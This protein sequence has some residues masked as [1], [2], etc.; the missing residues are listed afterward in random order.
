MRNRKQL[1]EQGYDVHRMARARRARLRGLF[2]KG[3]LVIL[4]L[5]F[6]TA[7]VVDYL[8][9]LPRERIAK[10]ASYWDKVKLGAEKAVRAAYLSLNAYDEDP[11]HSQLPI[12]ELYIKGKRLDKLTA[13]LPASGAEY[14]SARV[15]LE[16]KEFKADVRF[17]GD[18]I[19]HWAFPNRSWRVRLA[20][21][22]DYNGMQYFNLNVPRVD[23]QISNWLGYDIA[24]TLSGGLVP[25]SDFVHFR[26]NRLYD[27]VR[28]FLEQP[29]QDFLRKRNL[30][31]GKIFVGDI[32]SEQIYGGQPRKHLYRD[33]SAW[34]IRGLVEGER[35]DEIA[36]LVRIIRE[37]HD[38]Y[39]FYYAID[40]VFD[41]DALTKFIATLELV[42]TVH[43]DET[44]NGKYYFNP[45]TGKFI[46]IV[47]DTVAY[48]WKNRAQLDLAS[49]SLFRVVLANPE[50]REK[51]DR[52]LWTAINGDL[53]TEKIQQKVINKADEIRLDIYSFPLKL[54][55]NDKGIRHVSN[56]EWNAAVQELLGVIRERN[57]YIRSELS[58]TAVSQRFLPETDATPGRVAFSVGSRAGYI[59]RALKVKLGSNDAG[60]NVTLR[61]RGI[62]D[63]G[64][65]IKG[66]YREQVATSK[67]GQVT[68]T[69]NDTLYSKRSFRKNKKVG[70][71]IP[72]TYV[73]EVVAEGPAQVTKVVRVRGRNSITKE[74]YAPVEDVELDVPAEHKKN[75]VWWAPD[76]FADAKI[77]TLQGN[78]HLKA[79]KEVDRFTTLRIQPGT[80]LKMDPGV[81]LVVRGGTLEMLGSA[82]QPIRVEA[83]SADNPWGVLALNNGA[84]A[85]LRHVAIHG[86]GDATVSHVRYDG[87]LSVY[88]SKATLER[89]VVYSL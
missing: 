54:H 1:E 83:R 47:W 32:T 51:K 20:K 61:R 75:S 52:A 49:N 3:A 73:Y 15:K 16:N 11:K 37:E 21:G 25:Y 9:H 60:I 4:G 6:V 82:A 71:V 69:L 13:S 57:D 28:L 45:V 88:H 26:L 43:I 56:E 24:R 39:E 10:R 41:L 14:Q 70:E 8:S 81:S 46:P 55:A 38:P 78:V 50:L 64:R 87:S 62:D 34:D 66:E 72:A 12:V 36:E 76:H 53:A 58:A 85:T 19:N 48:F 42:G 18:S 30:P 17:R 65:P 29:N 40:S 63:I 68:F 86:G 5:L 33:T 59:L 22:K 80:Q 7:G 77:E 23:N 79:T 31:A 35:G 89:L 74:Q 44:H 27:G 2:Y 67:K 84:E